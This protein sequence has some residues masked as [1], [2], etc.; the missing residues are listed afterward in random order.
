MFVAVNRY[1]NVVDGVAVLSRKLVTFAPTLCS[2]ENVVPLLE[3]SMRKLDSLSELSTHCTST[4]R[5]STGEAKTF[6]GL[7]GSALSSVRSSS[8]SRKLRADTWPPI[9]HAD[10]AS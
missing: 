8:A 4:R 10:G 1:V 6:V 3:R 7:I 2:V 5:P 9:S